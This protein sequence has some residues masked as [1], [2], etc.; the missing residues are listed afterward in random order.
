MK[1][2]R[3]VTLTRNANPAV[4]I[5]TIGSRRPQPPVFW[6][7]HMRRS[8][9]GDLEV[10]LRINHLNH[11]NHLT[12]LSVDN[13]PLFESS[14]HH[15]RWLFLFAD[16]TR[17]VRLLFAALLSF[18]PLPPF[19]HRHAFFFCPAWSFFLLFLLFLGCRQGYAKKRF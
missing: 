4:S 18:P 9:G 1:C 6:G 8:L 2:S 13:N 7:G 17:R 11:L 14:S 19:V 12:C 10:T 3:S 16:I 5:I 15:H